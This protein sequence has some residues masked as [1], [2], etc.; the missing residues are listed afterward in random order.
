MKS[1]VIQAF[2]DKDTLVPYSVDN[3]YESDNQE[4]IDFLQ[5]KG[6]LQENKIEVKA[7][8]KKK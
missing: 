5:K 4:R 6:F 7:P 3:I 2:I 1:I 8:K